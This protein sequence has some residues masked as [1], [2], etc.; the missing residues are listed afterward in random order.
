MKVVFRA[1]LLG[2]AAAALAV[3]LVAWCSRV[4]WRYEGEGRAVLRLSWR[5]PEG[6]VET[7]RTLTPEEAARLPAHMRRPEVCEETE[8]PYLLRLAVD[9]HERLADTLQPAGARADRPVIV[10]R[11]VELTPG[12]H[13]I[14]VAFTPV[15]ATISPSATARRVGGDAEGVEAEGE[16][17]REAGPPGPL[18]LTASLRLA[19]REV[20]LV[21]Y[22][23]GAGNLVVRRPPGD[24]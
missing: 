3:V 4:G 16:A 21:T 13:E 10:F 17:E 6:A 15:L 11:E 14:E 23:V 1:A 5:A 24:P 20:A 9:G 22:D 12:A 18:R 2:W 7:C 8:L 19:P